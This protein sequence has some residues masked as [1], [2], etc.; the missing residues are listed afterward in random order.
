MIPAFPSVA[1][2]AV[3]DQAVELYWH[4]LC[5][6]VNFMDYPTDLTAL[7]TVCQLSKL[8]T[9]AG[10][11]PQT[12]FWGFTAAFAAKVALASGQGGPDDRQAGE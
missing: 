3:A 11:T 2:Q 9:Y 1:S 12:F 8:P 10:V 7:V 6:D 5:R 4:A